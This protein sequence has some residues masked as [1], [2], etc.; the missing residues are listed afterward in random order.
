[1]ADA[2]WCKFQY[3]DAWEKQ[4]LVQIAGRVLDASEVET[5][6]TDGAVWFYVTDQQEADIKNLFSRFQPLWEAAVKVLLVAFIARH[7]LASSK[8]GSANSLSADEKQFYRAAQL[9]ISLL[10]SD[11]EDL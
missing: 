5:N 4:L 3:R 1:M 11:P 8:L 2:N 9:M 10:D 7:Q 6:A